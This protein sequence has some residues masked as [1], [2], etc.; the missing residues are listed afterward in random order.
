MECMAERGWLRSYTHSFRGIPLDSRVRLWPRYP[1]QTNGSDYLGYCP[2]GFGSLRYDPQPTGVPRRKIHFS[3][4]SLLQ[5]P[6]EGNTRKNMGE[7][8]PL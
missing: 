8:P 5:E 2:I 6:L 1:I 7:M 4:V 3:E